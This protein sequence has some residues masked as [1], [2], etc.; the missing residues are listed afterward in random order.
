M[1]ASR[2]AAG[3][4]A[5]WVGVVVT[6]ASA[7]K[8]QAGSGWWPN[9]WGTEKPKAEAKATPRPRDDRAAE[10]AKIERAYNRWW[11]AC[12][13]LRDIAM[14]KED[15][16]LLEEVQRLNDLADEVRNARIEALNRRLT[17]P[18]EPKDG[19]AREETVKALTN[20]KTGEGRRFG[21]GRGER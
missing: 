11:E 15:T 3:L 5:L 9:W 21:A 14:S 4:A 17:T 13:R 8:P 18:P 12:D 19:E 7:Q 10:M 20:T 2:I 16:A 6:A 1:R